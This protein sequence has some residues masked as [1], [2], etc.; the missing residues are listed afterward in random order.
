VVQLIRSSSVRRGRGRLAA[1]AV[2]LA[3]LLAPVGVAPAHAAVPPPVVPTTF[4]HLTWSFAQVPPLEQRQKITLAMN[5]A[6]LNVNTVADYSGDVRVTYNPAL[7]TARTGYLGTIEF[8]STISS[9]IAQHELGRWLGIGTAPG[10][11]EHIADGVWTGASVLAR[12]RAYDGL[13]ARVRTDGS[14]FWPYGW[15][16]QSEYFAPQR[17][18]GLIGAFRA[19]MGLSDGSAA[20]NGVYRIQNRSNY[21]LISVNAKGTDVVQKSST[22]T[23]HQAWLLTPES[24]FW[25]IRAASSGLAIDGVGLTVNGSKVGYRAPTG[26]RSQ[27][28]ELV[29]VGS[30]WFYLR[31]QLTRMCLDTRQQD[32]GTVVR[33]WSCEDSN[34]DQHWRLA[35]R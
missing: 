10:F 9:G 19:D 14:D 26:V 32:A 4:G 30:G 25:T 12:I 8:S 23:A 29:E 22:T 3:A 27:R 28:W 11:S 33:Q 6:I 15:N 2:A 34:G 18:I 13:Q 1:L 35:L 7:S 16:T 20:A 24:G 17:Q 31:N 21:R 5:T